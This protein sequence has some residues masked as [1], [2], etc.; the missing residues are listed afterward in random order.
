MSGWR[1]VWSGEGLVGAQCGWGGSNALQSGSFMFT[2]V[3]THFT[4]D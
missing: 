2:R 4:V 3:C 1:E